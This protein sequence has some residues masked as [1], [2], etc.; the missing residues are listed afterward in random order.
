MHSQGKRVFRKWIDALSSS[1]T[2]KRNCSCCCIKMIGPPIATHFFLYLAGW[3]VLLDC[4][5]NVQLL[6]FMPWSDILNAA[7]IHHV[8]MHWLGPFSIGGSWEFIW[9]LA[10]FP[11]IQ[12]NYH[13][14]VVSMLMFVWSVTCEAWQAQEA[15]I[16]YCS[17][18]NLASCRA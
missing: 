7:R 2:E 4:S 17:S 9:S 16:N 11:S 14:L 13:Q 10:S 18:I 6:W 15:A 1:Y 3:T 12:R 8:C 5:T